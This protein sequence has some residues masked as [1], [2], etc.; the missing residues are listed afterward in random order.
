MR[1]RFLSRIDP[2]ATLKDAISPSLLA[3][4]LAATTHDT[5]PSTLADVQPHGGGFA[6]RPEYTLSGEL[7]HQRMQ[8]G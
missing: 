2:R 1:K 6:S 4:Q 7:R 3:D 5:R 8:G